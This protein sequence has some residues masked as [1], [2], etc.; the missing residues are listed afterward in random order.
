MDPS[1]S[2][3]PSCP[4]GEY[5]TP[6]CLSYCSEPSYSGRYGTDKKM[7][8]KAYSLRVSPYS[9]LESFI[10]SID[11]AKLTCFLDRDVLLLMVPL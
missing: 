10:V 3:Y 2:G 7:A 6:E 11:T 1:V 4:D 8:K 9:A 5:P